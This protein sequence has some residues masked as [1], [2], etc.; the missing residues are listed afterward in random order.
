MN[1]FTAAVGAALSMIVTL[2][3]DLM[4]IVL[5]SLRISLSA[6]AVASI[7]ALPLGAAIALALGVNAAAL[8]IS[9]AAQRRYG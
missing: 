4:E 8:V 7:V 2:D 5:L 6:V 1:E 9:D 3:A